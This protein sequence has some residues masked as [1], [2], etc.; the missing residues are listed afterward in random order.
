MSYFPMLSINERDIQFILA[1]RNIELP[2]NLNEI[3][4]ILKTATP[5]DM[6]WETAIMIIEDG[7]SPLQNITENTQLWL[8]GADLGSTLSKL[9]T[10]QGFISAEQIE[11]AFAVTA[12]LRIN[13]ELP[14]LPQTRYFCALIL[15]LREWVHHLQVD[16]ILLKVT[17]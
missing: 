6:A 16:K 4:Q 5:S 1:E 11:T 14:D 10:E 13:R 15:L 7:I 12:G 2:F 17:Q 3:E 9:A 8:Q